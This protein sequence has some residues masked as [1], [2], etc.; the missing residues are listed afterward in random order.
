MNDELDATVQYLANVQEQERQYIKFFT[1]YAFPEEMR[2]NA[3]LA[4]SF[5]VHSL[6]GPTLDGSGNRGYFEPIAQA[7]HVAGDKPDK[8]DKLE[9]KF[10]GFKQVPGSK[11]LWW[12]DI[13]DYNWTNEAFE[14]VSVTE[15][16]I[17]KPWVTPSYDVLRE[18]SGNALVRLDW[19][20][21]HTA[22][23]T[24]QAD[25]NLTPLYYELMYARVGVPKTADQYRKLWNIDVATA[26]THLLARGSIVDKGQSIVSRHARELTGLRI[27]HGY[28]WESSDYKNMDNQND[29]LENLSIERNAKGIPVHKGIA[30][31]GDAHEYITSNYLGLQTYFLSDGAGK[32]IEFA[33]PTIVVDTRDRIGDVRVRTAR[34]CIHCHGLG[35]NPSKN[36]LRAV[37]GDGVDLITTYADYKQAARAYYLTTTEQTEQDDAILYSRAVLQANGLDS[38]ENSEMFADIL[39][40][41]DRD[42]T[43]EQAAVECGVTVAEFRT[44][45]SQSAQGRLARLAKTGHPIPREVWENPKAGSFAQAMLLINKLDALP[46]ETV[47]VEYIVVQKDCNIYSADKVVG[48][49]THGQKHKLLGTFQDYW[50]KLEVNGVTGYV[51][52]DNI[53]VEKIKE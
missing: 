48:S 30:R 29:V 7:V 42:V 1:S 11:T 24:R 21:M 43:L 33:D 8:P 19:F 16:Y 40:W 50:Y 53:T 4:L 6:T 5:W 41:Y 37:I 17:R 52:R 44:K 32:R 14:K 15:P 10:V 3:A 34:S 23:T 49:C 27:G 35:I 18:Q 26:E 31:K 9:R 46:V 2:E 45:V 38:L 51:S 13:R 28:H 39:N 36:E 20:L 12:I 47:E 22:D 25:R